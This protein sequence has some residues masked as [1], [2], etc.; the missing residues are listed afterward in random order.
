ME[1]FTINEFIERYQDCDCFEQ[2][3][4]KTTIME[5]SEMI[6]AQVSPCFRDNTWNNTTVPQ[7]IKNASMEQARFLIEQDIPHVD[8]K[9]IKSGSMEAEL[10][11]EYSTLALTM[12]A[13]GGYIYR[14]SPINYNMSISVPI[15]E[16]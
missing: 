6:F 5:A 14:G 1:F 4:I 15:V 2:N 3:K 16:E 9:K 12:L 13:N 10:Q 8:A 7:A 11:S